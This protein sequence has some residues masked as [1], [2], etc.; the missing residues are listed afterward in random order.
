MA[1]ELVPETAEVSPGQRLRFTLVNHGPGGAMYGYPYQVERQEDGEWVEADVE[2]PG[3]AFVLPA[4][5][6]PAGGTFP[7]ELGLRADVP[8][9][10]YRVIKG[11]AIEGPG[12]VVL[13][14]EFDVVAARRAV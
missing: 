2:E 1:A 13:S 11:V 6:M 9:G 8:P 3:T 10:R 12:I 4:R 14:F 7:Q 5:S